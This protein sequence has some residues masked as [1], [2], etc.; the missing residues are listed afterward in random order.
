[1]ID[2]DA[3]N[4]AEEH[5]KDD[6]FERAV[7]LLECIGRALNFVASAERC[8]RRNAGIVEPTAFAVFTCASSRR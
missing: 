8:N 5:D 7:L 6:G 2:N 1:M 3:E 4:A